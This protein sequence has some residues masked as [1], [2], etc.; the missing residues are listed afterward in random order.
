MNHCSP[1]KIF[2]VEI[3]HKRIESGLAGDNIGMN[4]KNLSKDNPPRVCDIMIYKNDTSLAISTNF[5]AQIQILD[6]LSEIKVGYSPIGHVRCGRAACRIV[7]L[8]YTL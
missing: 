6:I 4:I 1:G 8:L 5:T 7:K 3:H 2:T